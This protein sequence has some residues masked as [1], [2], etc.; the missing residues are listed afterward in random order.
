MSAKA[1]QENKL[2]R[3]TPPVLMILG[4]IVLVFDLGAGVFYI[5]NGGWKTAAQQDE[6]YKHE[7]L[8]ILAAK[9]GEMAPLEAENKLRKEQGQSPLELPK[10]RQKMATDNHQKL[11]ELQKQLGARQGNSTNP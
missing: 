4:V 7:M 1:T 3:E 8:P 11:E 5:Y 9:H 10:D 2:Q 6:A